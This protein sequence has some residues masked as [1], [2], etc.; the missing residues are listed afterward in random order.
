MRK[1]NR[2]S[3]VERVL[4]LKLCTPRKSP[5]LRHSASNPE[6]EKLL[7]NIRVVGFDTGG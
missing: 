5:E 2:Q 3:N 4:T 7:Q 6:F 1:S